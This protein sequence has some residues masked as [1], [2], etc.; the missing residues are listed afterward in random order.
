MVCLTRTFVKSAYQK[1]NFPIFQP[2]HI[3]WVLKK[4]VKNNFLNFQPKHMFW[5]L[6]RTVSMSEYDQ[7][8]TNSSHAYE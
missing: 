8:V 7:A 3:L 6:K 1:N 2:I 4:T 5:V